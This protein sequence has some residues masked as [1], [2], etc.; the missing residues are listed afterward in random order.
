MKTFKHFT[1]EAA[2]HPMGVHAYPTGKTGQFKVHAIGSKVK[3]VGVGDTVRSS[4]LDDL[5][6]A[7]H[8]IKEI[9]RPMS[10]STSDED[11]HFARQS[12]KMQDA[13]N[14]HLR[15]G[16]DYEEA[17]KRAKVHVK[18]DVEQ[19][20]EASTP[21]IKPTD[22]HAWRQGKMSV[23]DIAKK[24]DT[25]PTRARAEL[26]LHKDH[27]DQGEEHYNKIFKH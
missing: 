24:Y 2:I 15:K 23:D 13:I 1:T 22:F 20:E 3:H 14:L 27:W 7:G 12:K 25:H 6:D 4:D 10:E 17:V 5:H 8:K 11:A 26:N 16:H 18:E 19:I 9:K 21:E